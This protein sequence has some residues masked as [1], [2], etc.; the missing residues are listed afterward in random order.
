M[1][2]LRGE[3]L[4]G[5][6][7]TLIAIVKRAATKVPFDI[8]VI[9]GLRTDEQCYINFGKG[10]TPAECIKGN[11]PAKYSNTKVQ[12]VTW[13]GHALSSNHRKKSDGFGHA[14]DL[15]PGTWTDLKVYDAMAKAMREAAAELGVKN[16]RWGADWDR[17]G[18]IRERGE[19]D[20]P[21]FELV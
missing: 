13:V 12:K 1:A 5:L 17:D 14:V 6:H 18:K 19:N 7:P 15:F 21:H 11:C 9:E 8:T 20:N 3:R 4:T 16:M 2:L 10:R